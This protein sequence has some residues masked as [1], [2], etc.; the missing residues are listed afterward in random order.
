MQSD[1]SKLMFLSGLLEYAMSLLIHTFLLHFIGGADKYQ[2]KQLLIFESK[3]S[4]S[5][6]C[7]LH[8]LMWFSIL[9]L[10]PDLKIAC[11]FQM[12]SHMGINDKHFIQH[13]ITF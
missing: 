13:H 5:K 4:G 11:L 9:S 12:F 6:W 1:M 2:I 8:Y 3:V 7:S 10:L